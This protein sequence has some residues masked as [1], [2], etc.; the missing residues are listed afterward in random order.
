MDPHRAFFDERGIR[1]YAHATADSIRRCTGCSVLVFIHGGKVSYEDARVRADSI[2][3]ALRGTKLFPVLIS[4]DAPAFPSYFSHARRPHGTNPVRLL[5]PIVPL[6]TFGA[7]LTTAVVQM[8]ATLANQVAEGGRSVLLNSKAHYKDLKEVNERQKSLG[9][10]GVQRA[11][12]TMTLSAAG[13]DIRNDISL[14][15][16]SHYASSVGERIGRTTSCVLFCWGLRP[17]FGSVIDG[18]GT[19]MYD[20]M[21][22]RTWYL[23]SNELYGQ[24]F[25]TPPPTTTQFPIGGMKILTDTLATLLNESGEVGKHVTV[26]AHSMGA[27]VANRMFEVRPDLRVDDI[28]F[29]AAAATIAETL[30]GAIAHVERTPTSRFYNLTL[31]PDAERR[32]ANVLGIIPTGTLLVW[33]DGFFVEPS[34]MMERTAGQ[35]R[36]QLALLDHVKPSARARVSVKMFGHRDSRDEGRECFVGVDSHGDF[37]NVR[38]KF[39]DPDFYTPR[40]ADAES[41]CPHLPRSDRH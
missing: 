27:I 38:L 39:W 41:A 17:A 35:Y 20:Q 11:P 32:E 25:R 5:K 16:T 37:S 14:I 19:G 12:K 21:Q 33:I 28:V 36:N 29:A 18:L 4:W 24:A 26:Y 40:N 31:H 9:P 8:P 13:P 30:S 34:N 10:I 6:V 23:F 15:D 22:T 1:E 7:D 2:L 3:S